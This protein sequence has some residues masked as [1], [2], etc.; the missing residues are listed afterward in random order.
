MSADTF[1]L[2][3][4]YVRAVAAA[5]SLELA[6]L[7]SYRVART[8]DD[9]LFLRFGALDTASLQAGVAALVAAA[10]NTSR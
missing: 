7:S 4:N 5:S 8:R 6:L 3:R 1:S 10:N 2:G 9:G